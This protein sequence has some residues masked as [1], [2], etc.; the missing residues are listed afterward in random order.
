M[1]VNLEREQQLELISRLHYLGHD[2][3]PDH[4]DPID[5]TSIDKLSFNDPIVQNA[6]RSYQEF[7]QTSLDELTL[8]QYGRLSLHD[9]DLG[10]ATLD[11][12]NQPR[13][14]VPDYPEI[15][16]G[17]EA[18]TRNWPVQCRGGLWFGRTF[19]SV[20]TLTEADTTRAFWG[21]VNNITRSLAD[22]DLKARDFGTQGR[23]HIKAAL[24]RLQGSTLAW[25]YLATGNCNAI[26]D[27]AYNST[28]RWTIQ[29]LCTVATHEI[30]HAMGMGHVRDNSATMF[31]SIHQRSLA[32]YGYFNSTDNAGMRALGYRLSGLG[33]SSLEELFRRRDRPDPEPDPEPDPPGD[34]PGLSVRLGGELVVTVDG[35]NHY[36]VP[37]PKPRF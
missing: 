35:E 5:E 34:D 13:C 10:P 3:N 18:A 26:L 37:I 17:A 6:V 4:P 24:K 7:F 23:L 25:S 2:R 20:P 15:P 16:E 19:R 8:E 32:R 22:V 31:P 1:P 33:Q 11:L 12:L 9:G 14:G 30:G 29:Y 28:V 27:Q 21:A 36:F